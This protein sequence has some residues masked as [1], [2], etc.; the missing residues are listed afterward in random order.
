MAAATWLLRF[1]TPASPLEGLGVC[2]FRGA[3]AVLAPGTVK[4]HI[5][6]IPRKTGSRNRV[7]IAA[8]A[9]AT[10]RAEP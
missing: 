4:N 9:W 3:G 5:A 10:G 8:W 7:A 2:A 6:A 1:F